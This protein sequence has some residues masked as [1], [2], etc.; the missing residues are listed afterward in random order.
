MINRMLVYMTHACN[1]RCKYCSGVVDFYNGVMKMNYDNLFIDAN[2]LVKYLSLH[3][4]IDQVY[5]SG[6]EPTLHPKLKDTCY[7]LINMK[8]NVSVITNLSKP[9]EYYNMLIE[10]GA[11]IVASY[12]AANT[13]FL[14][15]LK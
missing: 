15:T 1:Y 8:K 4:E 10:A 2:K 13:K 11:N 3:N 14:N 12:H 5:L 9:A 6:G 7:N